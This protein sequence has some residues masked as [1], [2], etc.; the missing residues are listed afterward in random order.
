METPWTLFQDNIHVVLIHR[1][2]PWSSGHSHSLENSDWGFPF[3]SCLNPAHC[4]HTHLPDLAN[5]MLHEMHKVAARM[6]VDSPD[7][8]VTSLFGGILLLLE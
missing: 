4:F 1:I 2:L 5:I 8:G 3:S 6:M 7:G